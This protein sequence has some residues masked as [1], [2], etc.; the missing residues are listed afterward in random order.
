[1]VGREVVLRDLVVV[2]TYSLGR[3]GQLTLARD[4]LFIPTEVIDPNDVDPSGNAFEGGQNVGS[5][6]AMDTIDDGQN[7]ARG[8]DSMDEYSRQ[9]DKM[10]AAIISLRADVVGLVELQNDAASEQDLVRS[11]NQKLGAEVYAGCGVPADLGRY[12]G[13]SDAIRVGLIYRQ[14]K[15]RAVGDA[16]WIDDPAFH[17]ARTPLSQTFRLI[18]VTD[19]RGNDHVAEPVTVI[20]NHFKSKGGAEKANA[21]NKDKGDGQGAYNAARRAQAIAV[22]K[23][24]RDHHRADDRVLVIGDLN[25]YSQEDP[26][27]AL[28]SVGLIDWKDFG[29]D[30]S[31]SRGDQMPPYSYVYYGQC[32]SLDHALATPSLADDITG[33]AAWHINADEPTMLD[34]NQEYNPPSLYRADPWRC[35]DHDPVLIGVR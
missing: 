12:P 30:R 34:Y 24:I 26:I 17:R 14:D 21:A 15:V 18:D 4:R 10:V 35:S 5:V 22:S 25:A 23:Y 19:W 33:V 1:M 32:G 9:R 20:V 29:S 7:G 27:D 6:I 8:A 13:G 16:V 3:R 11:I 28:R 31:R 2:D